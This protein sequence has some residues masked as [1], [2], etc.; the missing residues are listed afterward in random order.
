MLSTTSNRLFEQIERIP[1]IDTHEHLPHCD[2]A[3]QKDTDILGEYLLHYMSSDL[4]SAGLTHDLLSKIVDSSIPISQ[5][6]EWV[7]PY[8][9]VCRYTGYGRALDI[10]ARGIYGIDGVRRSTIEEL[11]RAFLGSLREGHFRHVLKDLCGIRISLLDGFAG[12]FECDRALFRRVWRPCQYVLPWTGAAIESVERTYGVSIRSL[13]DWTDALERELAD[14]LDHGAVALKTG[15][16]Y[17]R[18]LRFEEVDY[19]TA[20]AAFAS[21]MDQW[22]RAGRRGDA[23]VA[24]SVELQDYMMHSILGRASERNLTFQFHTGLQEGNGNIVTNSDPALLTNLFMKY[25][26]VDFDV[27]HIGY[28]FQHVV[29][30]LCKNFPNVFIDM[31][32]A[33]I[34]SPAAVRDALSDY[35]DAVPYNKISAFGG[36]YCFV[37]GVYGHLRL[38]RG[39]VSKVLSEKV[40][41]GIFSEDKALEIARALFYENPLRIFKLQGKL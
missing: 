11:N 24:F 17:E 28:P 15:L 39:N 31:C 13:D 27:F 29:S 16:A 22:E 14:A 9:E 8:W 7:E 37:D 30:A 23:Q 5:R 25:P 1:V 18:S 32:W 21:C 2:E 20:K 26:N 38:A 35:L 41:E 3:R 33:H 4:R 40:D 36:D 19:N 34:V 6:W 10:A 12:R